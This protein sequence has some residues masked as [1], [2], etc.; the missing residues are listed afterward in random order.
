MKVAAAI[1]CFIGNFIG[2]SGKVLL[3]NHQNGF[4]SE[5]WQFDFKNHKAGKCSFFINL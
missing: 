1:S 5:H 2:F 3:I 4:V